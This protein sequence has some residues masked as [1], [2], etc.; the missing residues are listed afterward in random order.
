MAIVYDWYENPNET[1]DGEE[2]KLHPRPLMNG[3]VTTRTLCA[4][5]HERSS[6]TVGDVK[7][8]LSNMTQITGDE[9]CEGRE[10]HIEGL[11]YFSVTLQATEPVTRS[12]PNKT[13]KVQLKTIS[14]RPD[15]Q[16]KSMLTSLRLTQSKY[17]RHSH[18]LTEAEIDRRLTEYF[19]EHEVMLRTDFEALCSMVRA[20]A[21]RHLKRL[22]EEGKLYNVGRRRQPLYRPMPGYY[23]L[24]SDAEQP[25][26]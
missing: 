1:G 11:G 24:S 16:L 14:F 9:L 21:N 23:G 2:K 8:A 7:N 18:R 26:R 12:T 10:V 22:Q 3:K 17:V 4:R 19:A 20:T 25:S 15:A 13:S 5:I 6:L